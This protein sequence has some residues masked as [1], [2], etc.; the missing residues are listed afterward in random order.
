MEYSNL[1]EIILNLVKLTL[2]IHQL[3][4]SNFTYESILRIIDTVYDFKSEKKIINQNEIISNIDINNNNEIPWSSIVKQSGNIKVNSTINNPCSIS[5]TLKNNNFV[6]KPEFFN[7][8]IVYKRLID[9]AKKTND[10]KII[11][12][13][14]DYKCKNIDDVSHKLV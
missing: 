14:F 9:N 2:N 1:D 8:E 5:I 7:D 4:K 12:T 13:I 6:N 3:K 11:N 10:W